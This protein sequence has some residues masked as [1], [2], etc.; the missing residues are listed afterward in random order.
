MR[1]ICAE[2]LSERYTLE[3]IDIYQYPEAEAA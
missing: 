3:V 1:K 2:Y